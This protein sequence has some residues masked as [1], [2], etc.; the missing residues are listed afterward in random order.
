MTAALTADLSSS[1]SAASA[2]GKASSSTTR[3]RWGRQ[4]WRSIDRKLEA[5]CRALRSARAMVD[6]AAMRRDDLFGNRESDAG[7]VR[8][9]G[10][11]QFEYVHALRNA[12]PSIC[13]HDADFSGDWNMRLD[14]H[15]AGPVAN[16]VDCVLNQIVQ[17]AA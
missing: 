4:F 11:E 7:P 2:P 3:T 1:R 16:R 14:R 5:K 8:F 15:L 6:Q 10:L 12:R 9:G 17:H 13:H